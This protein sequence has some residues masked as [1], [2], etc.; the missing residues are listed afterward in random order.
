VIQSDA[1]SK[2]EG[3]R[4]EPCRPCPPLQA[5]DLQLT[6]R[7]R[8]FPTAWSRVMALSNA[9]GSVRITIIR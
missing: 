2:T 3:R 4:F 9:S 5:K 8:T 1:I 6:M 7:P